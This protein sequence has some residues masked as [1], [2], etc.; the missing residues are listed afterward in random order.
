M[1]PNVETERERIQAELNFEI[2][3]NG[4]LLQVLAMTSEEEFYRWF[5]AD[6]SDAHRSFS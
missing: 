4:H 5:D 3:D 6:Q 1:Q 2:G